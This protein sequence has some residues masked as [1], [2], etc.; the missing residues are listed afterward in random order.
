MPLTST[1]QVGGGDIIAIVA[2]TADNTL[3]TT[4]TDA[5]YIQSCVNKMP[6]F[7]PDKEKIEYKTLDS[8]QAKSLLGGRG[9]IDGAISAYFTTELLE[10]HTYMVTQQETAAGCFWIVWYID[11]ENRTVGVRATCDEKI[12]TPEDE[13][14]NLNLKEIQISNID[15]AVQYAQEGKPSGF[16]D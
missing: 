1:P 11:S 9:S 2:G 8:K 5:K 12:K 4:F 14:G 10:A 6:Q 3:P 16:G 13:S 15:E 7:F